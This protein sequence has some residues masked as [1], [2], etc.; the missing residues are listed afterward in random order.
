MSERSLQLVT[1]RLGDEE[2]GIDIKTVQEIN[3]MMSITKMPNSPAHVEGVV[4][5][6]GKVIPVV[7]LRK[8]LGFREIERDKATR[9]MVVEIEGRVLGFIVDSVS[10]VLRI[11]DARVEPAPAVTGTADSAHIEGVINL[12]DRILLLLDLKILFGEDLPGA[13]AAA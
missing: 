13:R 5:L 3:R 4:D 8:K 7:S 2:F 1:F 10:E 11:D 9:I 12:E 6:R